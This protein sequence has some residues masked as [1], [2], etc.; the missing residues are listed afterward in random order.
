[1]TQR[2]IPEFGSSH[3]P[4]D[5]ASRNIEIGGLL[6][7]VVGAYSAAT[8]TLDD[9]NTDSDLAI[10][11]VAYDEVTQRVSWLQTGGSFVNTAFD[12][13]GVTRRSGYRIVVRVSLSDGRHYNQ[14]VFQTI[15]EH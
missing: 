14:S 10:S 1:M 9:S 2:E 8:V 5:L 11:S 3:D 13:D 15:S 7:K 4:A 6:R 12:G